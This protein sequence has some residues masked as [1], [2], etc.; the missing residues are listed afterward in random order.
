MRSINFDIMHI[1]YWHPGMLP[2]LHHDL[3][4]KVNAHERAAFGITVRIATPAAAKTR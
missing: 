1:F 2:R 3:L 4:T